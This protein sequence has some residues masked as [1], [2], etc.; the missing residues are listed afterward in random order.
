MAAKN[1]SSNGHSRLDEAMALLIHNQAEFVSS[2]ADTNR[3]HAETERQHLENERRHLEYERASSERFDRIES[4][5]KEII[6][7]LTDHSRQLE[8]LTEAV[9]DRIGFKVA[10]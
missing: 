9:R 8:R 4:Q 5:M 6:R 3:R 2:M 7:V 10:P 1:A